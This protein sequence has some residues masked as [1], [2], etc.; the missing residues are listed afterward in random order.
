MKLVIFF[1]LFMIRFMPENESCFCM[2]IFSDLLFSDLTKSYA[3]VK[4]WGLCYWIEWKLLSFSFVE[5]E[6]KSNHFWSTCW[7]VMGAKNISLIWSKIIDHSEIELIY[8]IVSAWFF[9]SRSVFWEPKKCHSKS[10]TFSV[11]TTVKTAYHC[12]VFRQVSDIISQD[13][14][15]DRTFTRR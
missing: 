8:I 15:K 11:T 12:A 5:K 6:W 3:I 4:F 13:N 10:N 2:N 7:I 14:I 1:C 9:I